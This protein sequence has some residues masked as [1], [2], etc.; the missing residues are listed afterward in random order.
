[1]LVP[2]LLLYFLPAPLLNTAQ[3]HLLAIFAASI[4]ALVAQPVPMGVSTTVAITLLALTRTV[5]MD[6]IFSG[7]SNPTVWLIFT[8]FLFARAV[9][10]TGF[11]MRVAYTFIRKFGRSPLTLGYSIAGS[12]FVLAPFIPSD[13]ARGG[14]IICPIV[15]SIAGA[16]GAEPGG[17]NSDFGAFLTLVGFHTTYTAS[18]M[19]LTGMAANPLMA[20][21]ARNVGH[22]DLTW[23]R[24]A[25]GSSVPGLLALIVLPWAIFRLQPPALRDTEPARAHAREELDNMGALSRQERWLVIILL[26]VM[27]GWVT[28]PW[29]G[30]SNTIVALAGVSALLVSNVISWGDL[31]NEHRAWE[32]LI[33]FG[34]LIMMADELLRAG[35][36]NALSQRAFHFVQGWTAIAAL[37]GLLLIYMYVHY[38]FASMTAQVT[39]LYPGFLAAALVS[40]ANPLVAALSLA[41]FSNLNAAMTHYGTGSAPV[42]FGTGYVSQRTWWKVGFLISLLNVAIWL[43]V[44]LMWWKLLGWW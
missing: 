22:V 21:F 17:I 43:G 33:W 6:R 8:A 32:A 15:R 26:L 5:P 14:G 11:G 4:I 42:Y 23:A 39:A 24:W 18:A 29:H 13:T 2:G 28:S 31:L 38:G 44:G 1:V 20:D 9:S 16:V 27:A 12:D 41:Y 36:V 3:R 10:G 25:I 19:F 35:V 40:G 34:A 7:Y 30:F 37:A